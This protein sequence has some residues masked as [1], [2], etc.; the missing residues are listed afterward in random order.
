M[1]KLGQI[2]E[3]ALQE[4]FD[5]AMNQVLENIHDLNTDPTKV[6]KIVLEIKVKADEDRDMLFMESTAKTTL[7]AR[8]P[9]ETKMLTGIGEDGKI[10]INELKSGKKDQTYFDDAGTVRTDVGTPVEESKVTKMFK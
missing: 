9:I 6:R 5:N 10:E 4:R 1:I 7:Q 3:G 8:T 2:A